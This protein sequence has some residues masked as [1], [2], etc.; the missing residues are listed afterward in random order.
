MFQNDR[1]SEDAAQRVRENIIQDHV[2]ERRIDSTMF[3]DGANKESNLRVKSNIRRI[4]RNSTLGGIG[5]GQE[6][7]SPHS[8]LPAYNFYEPRIPSPTLKLAVLDTA[9]L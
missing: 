9:A 5:R 7:S 4:R 6:S 1:R 8:T 2:S 3:S